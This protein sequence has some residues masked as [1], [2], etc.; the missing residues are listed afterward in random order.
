MQRLVGITAVL[1][2][3]LTGCGLRGAGREAPTLAP[4]STPSVGSVATAPPSATA[5]VALSPSPTRPPVATSAPTVSS[6]LFVR[7]ANTGG[8]G[9]YVRAAPTS[10]ASGTVWPEGTI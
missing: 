2:G 3:V 6:K 7:I 10:S 9:A 5:T 8:L 4:A 1:M